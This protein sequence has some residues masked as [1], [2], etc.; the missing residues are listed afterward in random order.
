MSTTLLWKNKLR[1]MCRQTDIFHHSHT[2]VRG[3]KP[4]QYIYTLYLKL[5]FYLLTSNTASV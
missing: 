5:L 2:M 3:Q 1:D 4:P